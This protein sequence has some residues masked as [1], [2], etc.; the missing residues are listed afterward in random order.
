[1][2]IGEGV[3]G[4]G[5]GWFYGGGGSGGDGSVEGR[6]WG[7]YMGVVELMEMEVVMATVMK[8]VAKVK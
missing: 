7:G 2:D 8:V 5:W 6:G 3:D 1:M 4:R